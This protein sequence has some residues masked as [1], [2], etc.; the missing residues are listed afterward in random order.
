M[1]PLIIAVISLALM[2]G[3]ALAAVG[4]RSILPDH[5]LDND[6]KDVVTR[7][8]GFVVTLA[9]LVLSLLIASGKGSHDEVGSRLR[10][11][12]TEF[13]LV[14]RSMASYGAETAQIRDLLRRTMASATRTIWPDTTPPG[15]TLTGETPRDAVER[16]QGMIRELKPA[17]ESQRV[18]QSEA[19][20]DIA[21]I[22]RTGWML[23]ELSETR[24]PTMFL[25]I[26][27]LWLVI[28]FFGFGLFAPRNRTVDATLLFCAFCAASAVFLILELYA[29]VSGLLAISP[30]TFEVVLEQL[31][32]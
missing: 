3:A 30:R 21:E 22:K 1:R 13:I 27:I 25:V 24:M 9:A 7:G 28:V 31:G 8:I 20:R 26:I 10:E 29:P 16:V 32:R 6:A 15:P 2:F 18:L 5:H 17:N 11:L 12:A 14:D 19:L 4:L 23:I